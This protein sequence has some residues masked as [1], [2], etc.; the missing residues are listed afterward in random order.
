MN[1]TRKQSSAHATSGALPGTLVVCHWSDMLL[2]AV[3]ASVSSTA[4]SAAT[5]PC[6]ASIGSSGRECKKM[7]MVPGS[8]TGACVEPGTSNPFGAPQLVAGFNLSGIYVLQ[9]FDNGMHVQTPGARFVV[10]DVNGTLIG[11]GNRVAGPVLGYSPNHISTNSINSMDPIS[12]DLTFECVTPGSKRTFPHAPCTC[13]AFG[14]PDYTTE[15]NPPNPPTVWSVSCTFAV[16]SDTGSAVLPYQPQ[17]MC[18]AN[19]LEVGSVYPS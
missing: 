3:V 16:L 5:W 19:Y 13:H 10:T 9:E 6:G 4:N 17:V 18:S 15:P 7:Q 12:Y 2:L 8:V 11:N 1:T 14:Q